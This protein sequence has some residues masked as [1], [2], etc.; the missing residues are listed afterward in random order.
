VSSQPSLSYYA[1]A[2]DLHG[3][4]GGVECKVGG[5]QLGMFVSAATAKPSTD[6]V[7]LGTVS[8][9]KPFAS[10][11]DKAPRFAQADSK[12]WSPKAFRSAATES[13]SQPRIS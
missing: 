5:P 7:A 13:R 2:D 1:C 6:D 12:S 4:V 9:A 11:V 8:D 3:V 10:S